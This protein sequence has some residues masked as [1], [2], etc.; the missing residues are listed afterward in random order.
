[1]RGASI[2]AGFWSIADSMED[3]SSLPAIDDD[4]DIDAQFPGLPSRA[5][6]KR[7]GKAQD[8]GKLH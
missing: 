6:Q 7:T 2:M 4:I 8:M 5:M 3:N 1:M